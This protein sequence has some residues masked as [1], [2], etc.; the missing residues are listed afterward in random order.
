MLNDIEEFLRNTILGLEGVVRWKPYLDLGATKENDLQH[1]FSTV[2]LTILILEI[3]RNA[4]PPQLS[5]D[6]YS[7]LA[8]AA[9]HD[10]GEIGVGDTLYK[11]K[12]ETSSELEFNSYKVQLSKLPDDLRNKLLYLYSLQY[13]SSDNESGNSVIFE[14]I[15]RTG[16]ILYAL[17]EYNKS[18]D[19]ILLFIQVLRNQLD[20]INRLLLVLP[21][22]KQIFTDTIMA[23][24]MSILDQYQGQFVEH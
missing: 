3:L 21:C 13:N 19:N 24:F 6:P 15:E 11:K 12:T 17:G 5:Y 20:H 23:R 9:L 1:S 2:I 8:C 7:I 22:C 18:E 16:Y 14:F 10:L 4:P